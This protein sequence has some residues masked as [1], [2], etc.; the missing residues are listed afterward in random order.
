MRLSSGMS[1][2]TLEIQTNLDLSL[3]SLD[4]QAVFLLEKLLNKELE[5]GAWSGWIESPQLFLAS[6]EFQELLAL[7]QELINSPIE[8]LVVVA[9]GGSY[10]GSRAVLEAIKGGL[11]NRKTATGC[12]LL[13]AGKSL[14]SKELNQQL[15]YLKTRK[16]AIN[17]ISKSGTT[18]E[19][20][21]AFIEFEKLLIEKEGETKARELIFVTTDSQQGSLRQLV[22]EKNYR[23]F[24]VPANIGGRFSVLTPV[25]IFPLAVAGVN[26]KELL[27]GAKEGFAKD[28]VQLSDKNPVIT[29]ALSRFLLYKKHGFHAEMLV[30]YEPDLALFSE[31]WKQL[32][33]ESEGKEGKSLLP[34]SAIFSTDLHSVGQFIQEGPR[35]FFQTSLWIQEMAPLYLSKTQGV[36]KEYEFIFEKPLHF[37]NK[38]VFEASLKAHSQLAQIPQIILKIPKINEYWLGQLFAFF[39][40]SCVIS[41]SLLQVNPFD[42]PGVEAYKKE[43]QKLLRITF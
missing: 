8:V 22:K 38:C 27:Q 1:Q 19:V 20:I 17:V 25:G 6:N 9:V 30:S 36:L 43:L 35:V 31:W 41:A 21:S 7:A 37:L 14:S 39:K 29:Y 18:L 32:F 28:F 26:V 16:F 11:N 3:A 34:L 5:G 13:F 40:L 12:E 23:S 33:A 24:V 2:L 42:Q 4:K 15:D 10:T